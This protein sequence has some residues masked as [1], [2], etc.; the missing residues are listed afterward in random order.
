MARNKFKYQIKGTRG[1]RYR[2]LNIDGGTTQIINN[3]TTGDGAPVDEPFLLHG[4]GSS[5]LTDKR[6]LAVD[7]SLLALTIGG[8]DGDPATVSIKDATAASVLVNADYTAPGQPAWL[9]IGSNTVLARLGGADVTSQKITTPLVQDA[10]ITYAKMQAVSV[11]SALLGRGTSG[12]TAV[13]EI[14]LAGGLSMSGD[15]LSSSVGGISDGDKGDITVSSSGAVWTIDANVVSYAKMQDVSAASRIIGRGSASGAGD[16]EELTVSTGLSLSGTTLSCTITQYTDELAQDAVGTIL[17][18]SATI[19]FTYNDGANTITAIVIDDSITYAKLQNASVGFVI[20]AKVG[21]GVGDYAEL[22][23]GTNTVVGRVAGDIVAAQVVTGQ[24]AD[25]AVTLAKIANAAANSTLVGSGAAG[26]GANYVEIT[27]GTNLSMSG[28]TL[29]ATGGGGG[30]P[31][32]S[33]GDVQYNDGAGGFGAEAAFNYDSSANQL[34]VGAVKMPATSGTGVSDAQGAIIVDGVI[35]AIFPNGGVWIGP[36]AGTANPGSN[37]TGIE[38]NIAIGY[39]AMS[40]LTSSGNPGANVGVG[41]GALAANT[42]SG[43]T[44]IGHQA[45][46]S[47]TTGA[48]NTCIGSNA[49]VSSGTIT[50]SVAVGEASVADDDNQATFGDRYIWVQDRVPDAGPST[51]A[52]V[53]SD[54]G[55]LWA[56]GSTGAAVQLAPAGGSLTSPL[57]A[58]ILARTCGA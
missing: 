30:S 14:T 11:A 22:A 2:R 54:S 10:A 37:W 44:G 50:N 56:Q 6:V 53:W 17:T 23:V 45:G 31:G 47:I 55:V 9:E 42:V 3:T 13:R 33:T 41:Y 43:N 15:V 5:T 1:K 35:Q 36:G 16:P 19:D 25:D 38:S 8:T 32:G 27:L 49:D 52:Y 12:G 58:Q 39:Y 7:T 46:D 34:T 40:A 48:S 29:N 57:H 4:T 24:I 28:T 20:L 26:A 51:G 21:T 18:D